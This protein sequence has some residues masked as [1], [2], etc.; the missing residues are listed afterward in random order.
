MLDAV[1]AAVPTSSPRTGEI[2]SPPLPRRVTAGRWPADAGE[3]GGIVAFGLLHDGVNGD[4]RDVCPAQRRPGWRRC[5]LA[6]RRVV[7]V[8]SG[9]D[10]DEAHPRLQADVPLGC[11]GPRYQG[12]CQ[13]QSTHGVV[14]PSF[15]GTILVGEQIRQQVVGEPDLKQ[16]ATT[17]G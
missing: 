12:F 13:P 16:I 9:H 6:F 7:D 17:I 8:P 5:W 4:L 2:S 3:P 14:E 10:Y 11:E 15:V 1:R